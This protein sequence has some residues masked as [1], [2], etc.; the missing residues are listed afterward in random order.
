M[1][2][3]FD[4]ALA[5]MKDDEGFLLTKSNVSELIAILKEAA[6]IKCKYDLL[7]SYAITKGIL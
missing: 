7:K 2:K 6:D 4:I 1:F 5:K 3:D